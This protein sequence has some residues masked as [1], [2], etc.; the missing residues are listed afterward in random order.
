VITHA[1][2]RGF[3]G[4]CLSVFPHDISKTADIELDI[5]CFTMSPPC[6]PFILGSKGQ[7]S[8]S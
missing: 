2:D 7:K 3:G 8:R 5:E 6:K 1:D 4:V